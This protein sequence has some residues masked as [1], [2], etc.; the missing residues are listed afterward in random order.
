MATS[1]VDSADVYA[2]LPLEG[3]AT[4]LDG[5]TTSTNGTVTWPADGKYL[6]QCAD[7]PGPLGSGYV[8]AHGASDAIDSARTL[9]VECWFKVSSGELGY[10]SFSNTLWSFSTSGDY[11]IWCGVSLAGGI[12][13]ELFSGSYA[14][15][16]DEFLNGA[17]FGSGYADGVWHFCQVNISSTALYIYVDGSQI[18][19]VDLTA[20]AAWAIDQNEF[21]VGATFDAPNFAGSVF[22]G[23]ISEVRVSKALQANT[24]P[25]VAM[26]Y[27]LGSALEAAGTAT[28]SFVG[29]ALSSDAA[30]T[31]AGTATS[32]WA[33]LAVLPGKLTASG[34][35][36]I[37]G[38]GSGIRL[39]DA[40]LSGIAYVT[41]ATPIIR[42]AVVSSAGVGDAAFFTFN[43]IV[44]AFAADGI[45]SINFR[46]TDDE[47]DF[48][49]L[50]SSSTALFTLPTYHPAPG[51]MCAGYSSDGTYITFP[52]SL[53]K[54][55][56]VAEAD[57]VTGDLREI[58]RN[59]LWCMTDHYNTLSITATS[60]PETVEFRETTSIRD[61]YYSL[62]RMSFRVPTIRIVLPEE[63]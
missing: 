3:D 55:L 14:P 33:G 59:M 27:E 53:F 40:Y 4:D 46:S 41:F 31:A 32:S 43:D 57:P 45:A 51:D 15:L 23:R 38:K 6:T 48:T 52:I 11:R 56:S 8:A 62:F 36:T 49:A 9:T 18:G 37:V 12:N 50:G 44:A 1:Y 17:N 20:Y 39:F 30:L 60:Q 35:G 10:Y 19:F 21:I 7:F 28:T 34:I 54:T 24:V 29:L 2:L 5:G 42:Q 63:P 58:A 47:T 22:G 16:F 61:E 26:V 25:P 13:F